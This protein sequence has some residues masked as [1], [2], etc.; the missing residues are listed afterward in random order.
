VKTRNYSHKA[1]VLWT[2]FTIN[3]LLAL[4]YLFEHLIVENQ[5]VM[6]LSGLLDNPKLPFPVLMPGLLLLVLHAFWSLGYQR[7]FL[8]LSTA[9]LSGLFFEIAGVHLGIVFGGDYS[10]QDGARNVLLGV[11]LLV[12][13]FW[14]AFIY[15]GYWL[16]S[17]F[18]IW[19]GKGKPNQIGGNHLWLALAVCLDGLAVVIIDLIMD[20]IQVRA[21]NWGWLDAG[22][23]F[24][25]PPANFLG[26]FLVTIIATGT[27]RTLEY[28]LPL[29]AAGRIGS[30][31]LI[32]T[33]GYGLLGLGLAAMALESGIPELAPIGAVLMLTL[34]LI[35]LRFF[36]RQ[37]AKALPAAE[38]KSMVDS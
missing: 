19:L 31:L 1:V 10:Y 5:S 28:Y 22:S 25:V 29:K 26:W 3:T 11:P 36:L 15:V 35:N 16:T 24:G 7:G 12:T 9:F 32:P 34:A 4:Y 23:F 13:L 6:P 8:L 17:S 18:F 21:G 30:A 37:R 27:F 33:V 2:L 14:V 38:L 20:P